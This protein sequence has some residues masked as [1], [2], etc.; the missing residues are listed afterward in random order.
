M[1]HAC[2]ARTQLCCYMST[3][4]AGAALSAAP[5][6]YNHT[7][8]QPKNPFAAMLVFFAGWRYGWRH[9]VSGACGPHSAV[10]APHA[11]LEPV[12]QQAEAA[13]R[14]RGEQQ[15]QQ[16]QQRQCK[17]W[18]L[19][20]AQQQ[21]QLLCGEQQHNICQ[22][23]LQLTKT[24]GAAAVG[25]VPATAAAQQLGCLAVGHQHVCSACLASSVHRQRVCCPLCW[26]TPGS[27]NWLVATLSY[28]HLSRWINAHQSY[29]LALCNSQTKC[30]PCCG[31]CRFRL[32][33]HPH[34]TAPAPHA[35]PCR[36]T[37]RAARRWVAAAPPTPR[38]TCAAALLTMMPGACLAGAARTCCPGSS[39][40]RPTARVSA[41]TAYVKN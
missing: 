34:V 37:S 33:Q 21:Q 35:L 9:D 30:S 39:P 12:Q 15:Q 27:A 2:S 1:C 10:P 23:Q 29:L 5:L 8:T 32:C 31:S 22:Q 25:K 13:D 41:H 16:Q 4:V 20:S 11:G 7:N 24:S 3:H 26:L 19:S 18:Q 28:D 14:P 38:C 40:G 6:V 36:C 17:H